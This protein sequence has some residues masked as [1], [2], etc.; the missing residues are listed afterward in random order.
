MGWLADE[1]G[2]AKCAAN[3]VPLTPLSHLKRAADLFAHR[4]A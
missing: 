2:L 1:A 4:T 3:Y